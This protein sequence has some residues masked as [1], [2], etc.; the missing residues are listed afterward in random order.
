[1]TT[2]SRSLLELVR[3]PE[4]ATVRVDGEI[5]RAAARHRLE[6]LLLARVSAARPELLDARLRAEAA[7][8]LDAL[9]ANGRRL[10]AETAALT[11]ALDEHGIPAFSI[12]GPALALFLWG[13]PA[14]RTS[15]DIDLLVPEAAAE[16]AVEVLAQLGFVREPL[17]DGVA[18]QIHLVKP[19]RGLV[20]DLHWNVTGAE[21]PFR[22]P[23]AELWPDRRL[24]SSPVGEVALLPTPWLVLASAVYLLKELPRIELVYLTDLWRLLA[25]AP[26]GTLEA[27]AELARATGTRRILALAL[28]LGREL[29]DGPALPRE[30]AS[31]AW[32][33][34]KLPR[35]LAAADAAE[36]ATKV[37]YTHRAR[38]FLAHLGLRERLTDRITTLAAI[39]PFLLRPDG[40]DH[41]AAP[42]HPWRARVAR[43]PSVFAAL[44]DGARPPRPI[45]SNSL[46][47]PGEEVS[48]HPLDEAG[49][50]LDARRGELVALS[51]AGAFLWCALEEGIGRAE[52]V[53]RLAAARRIRPDEAEA[54]LDAWLADL[55]AR[56]LLAPRRTGSARAHPASSPARAQPATPVRAGPV[57]IR[58]RLF[59]TVVDLGM[60]GAALARRVF[61]ALEHLRCDANPTLV[62]E[63][64]RATD[65][66]EL[67]AED[68]VVERCREVRAVPPMVKGGL[69]QLAANRTRFG[70]WIHAAMLRAGGEALL[71]PAAPGSGKTCLS[72]G[73]ARA[74]LAYHSDEITLLEPKTLAARGLPVALTVKR[75]AWPLIAK[76]Y[77]ELLHQPFHER[78]DGRI[79][80]YLPPPIRP[81]DPALDRAWPVRWIVLPSYRGGAKTRLEPVGRVEALRAL[82]DECLALRLPLDPPTVDRL[83]DWIGG[84]ECRRLVFG[85]LDEAVRLVRALTSSE[86]PDLDQKAA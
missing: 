29:L 65:G 82:L 69:V 37:K 43:I 34:R 60:P 10:L 66:F 20:V 61:P 17:S 54:E 75:D 44:A 62:V 72:A 30:L 25:I 27:A 86:T 6:P 48:F 53:A 18:R 77:P 9:R 47:R 74:G 35:V 80:R 68:R 51:P 84:I 8:R 76:R 13:D 15:R 7:V 78:V 11:R 58:L 50:L 46:P 4:A 85:D 41:R 79:V 2:A 81:G 16:E 57:R 1:M 42:E 32:L 5:L 55:A 49:L 38:E 83:V 12:K 36:H 21:M 33:A 28:A 52:T 40:E 31:A 24:V 14:V 64:V 26:A 71:L 22:L 63:L 73:L 67:V 39:V 59:D 23:V 45:T 3:A 19:T 70:L 56:D